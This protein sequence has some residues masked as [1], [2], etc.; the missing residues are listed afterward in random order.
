MILVDMGGVQMTTL[1][2]Q[3][4]IDST[5]INRQA[6]KHS[7]LYKLLFLRKKYAKYGNMI[8][9]YDNARESYWRKDVF[10]LYKAK[11]KIGR[12]KSDVDWE[13]FFGAC[14]EL[15][16]EISENIGSWHT[17]NVSKNGSR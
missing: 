9:C 10:P 11:R 8:L 17:M 4:D 2:G 13:N 6:L 1:H 15:R 7:L 3:K 5:D 12:E 14:N 16:E